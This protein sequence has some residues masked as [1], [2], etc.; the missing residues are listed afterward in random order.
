MTIKLSDWVFRYLAG[1]GVKHVFMV[2]GGGAMHLDDSL[3]QCKQIEYICTL[4]EQAAAMAAE[5][6]A[7]VTNDLGVCLVTAGPG[8]TNAITGVAGAWLDS[9]PMLVLSGQAKRAD[10]KGDTG[11]RQMGVQEVDIVSMVASTT[12]YAVTVMEPSDIRYHLEKA[13][14]L[15]RTGR[16]GPVWLDLP[17]DVQG[18]SIDEA[19][20]RGFDPSEGVIPRLASP[21]EIASAVRHSIE[22]LNAAER[23][24]VLVGNGVR[25]GGARAGMR[26]LIERLGLPVLTTWPAHDMV[27]DD[28]PLMVGRPGP[29][30][31]RGANFTLQN[32]DWLLALGARLDLVVT[33]YAPQNFARAAKKIMVDIDAA[34][35]RKMKGTVDVPVHADVKEFIDELTRQLEWVKPRDR[36]GWNARWREWQTTYPVVLPEYRDLS[37]G[38]STYVLSEA[39]SK[40]SAPDDVIVSGS[41]GAGIEIFCLAVRLKEGQRLFLTTAL[42]AMG[43]GLPGLLG[44]CLANGRRRT[45]CVDGDGGLQLNIQE[46]ETMR[47]LELP[48]KL[49]VLNNDGYAS[50]RTSQSRYFGRLAGADATSGVTLPPLRGV[51]EAYGLPYARIDTDRDLV[52]EVRALL[53]APG[54]VVIEVMTPREEPRA[55][56]LSSMRRADGSMVSKPLE[57]LWPFLPRDEFLSNMVIAPLDED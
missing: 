43:N 28:H 24:V 55:P 57:D 2:T 32:A 8:G 56:S 14:H 5:S 46:L 53:D 41:S 30:A 10:L 12:K 50:I 26:A 54:P 48:I 7:K 25:L 15:A 35:L 45:L 23:P 31:P 16:P 51:V 36:S 40:A 33:G 3:G 11:V 29:L 1:I 20:L 4:H 9:T 49:F 19:S 37:N 38:V 47:R 18:A 52:D 42:G 21:D 17:L 27:P 13:V 39:V 44:A 22:L 6:Y 34:E